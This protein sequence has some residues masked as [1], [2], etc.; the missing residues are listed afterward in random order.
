MY[1]GGNPSLGA[2][3]IKEKHQNEKILP[4]KESTKL[5]SYRAF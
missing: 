3:E 5:L 4:L 2:P 1:L